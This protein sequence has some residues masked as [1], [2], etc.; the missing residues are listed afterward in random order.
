MMGLQPN[1]LP[2]A[3]PRSIKTLLHIS[4]SFSSTLFTWKQIRQ[5]IDL[6]TDSF[7]DDWKC[8][9]TSYRMHVLVLCDGLIGC[10]LIALITTIV[11]FNKLLALIPLFSMTQKWTR[12]RKLLCGITKLQL[13]ERADL[14]MALSQVSQFNFW[15]VTSL[16]VI[17]L[18]SFFL[19]EIEPE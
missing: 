5:C 18:L 3:K 7:S 13:P 6:G 8:I 11:H 15:N 17:L 2:A 19:Q 14:S 16:F 9:T 1:A 12:K 10:T 4:L